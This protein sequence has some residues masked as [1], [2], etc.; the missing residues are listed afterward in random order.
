MR[1]SVGRGFLFRIIWASHFPSPHD[2]NKVFPGSKRNPGNARGT[3]RNRRATTTLSPILY[4]FQLPSSTLYQKLQ[5][6]LSEVDVPPVVETQRRPG[7]R[8]IPYGIPEDEW[9]RVLAR[10]ANHES[11][12]AIAKDYHVSRET[13]RRLVQASKQ[14]S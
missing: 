6:V 4:L 5:K 8:D 11:Y 12:R 7:P 14:A 13:I 10:V 2:P 1:R 9:Q 3:D